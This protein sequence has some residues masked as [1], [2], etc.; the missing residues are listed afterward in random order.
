MY[1]TLLLMREINALSIIILES[2]LND[3]AYRESHLHFP[4]INSVHTEN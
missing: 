2:Y 1:I 3:T 4:L